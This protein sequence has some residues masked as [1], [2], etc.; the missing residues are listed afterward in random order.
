[1]NGLQKRPPTIVIVLD[2][3]LENLRSCVESIETN[4][5]EPHRLSFVT[6]EKLSSET[7]AFI[8]SCNDAQILYGDATNDLSAL[9][10][11]GI[12][13][14]DSE[15][16]ALLTSDALPADGWF[17]SLSSIMQ[18]DP[19]IGAV[20][21]VCVDPR[22][23]NVLHAGIELREDNHPVY[24]DREHFLPHLQDPVSH[25]LAVQTNGMMLRKSVLDEVGYFAEGYHG[26]Y[27][28]V[29]LCL[30]MWA[31][32]YK[33]AL[34]PASI[35]FHQEKNR[36]YKLLNRRA[37]LDKL[38]Q[39]IQSSPSIKAVI[40]TRRNQ[41]LHLDSGVT[42]LVSVLYPAY[43]DERFLEDNI[44]S[45]INQT[46]RHWELLIVNDASTDSTADILQTYADAYPDKIKV[47]HKDDH[48]RFEAWEMLYRESKGK[49]LAIIGADDVFLPDKLAQ[50]VKILEGDLSCPYV[51]SDVYHF[52][53]D[54]HLITLCHVEDPPPDRQMVRLLEYNILC[55]PAV[56]LRRD[57]VEDSGGWLN[58]QFLYAQDYDLLL[59]LQK[60]R[61]TKCIHEP[62]LKYRVHQWQLTQVAGP[63]KMANHVGLVL[64]DKLKKWQPEDFFPGWDLDTEEGMTSFYKEVQVMF[65]LGNFRDAE[66]QVALLE[67]LEPLFNK[68]HS[69]SSRTEFLSRVSYDFLRNRQYKLAAFYM[70]KVLTRDPFFGL[71][72][73]RMLLN[74]IRRRRSEFKGQKAPAT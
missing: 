58:R 13:S 55:T 32:G 25:P 54:G 44:D 67:F 50:Q 47:I 16:V 7:E 33:V 29:D 27:A 72:F 11:L 63:K 3:P 34:S 36:R 41:S 69:K 10:N 30:R 70:R 60:G 61:A 5:Q 42:S 65:F 48:D 2:A 43:N 4:V 18:S 1:M 59:R 8:R 19:R 51:H 15:F 12:H 9:N 21:S 39:S 49:Y 23:Q 6:T 38:S 45:I 14:S 56:L 28:D 31:A 40:E 57:A 62:L 37:N 22:N 68:E 24:T 74:R 71:A 35:L 64:S 17:Q 53:D 66:L 20:G 26:E 52:D 73:F 46:Y